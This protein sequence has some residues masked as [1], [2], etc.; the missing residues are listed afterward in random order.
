MF[1]SRY[2][3]F[4]LPMIEAMYYGA[5]VITASNSSL[6]EAAG[7]A[8]LLFDADDIDGM[9]QAI[10]RICRDNAYRETLIATGKEHA[11]RFSWDASLKQ[12]KELIN[13]FDGFKRK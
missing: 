12:W 3:G 1:P 7:D 11:K 6:I 8:G 13:S 9:A 10:E 4:G 2:E 5:P